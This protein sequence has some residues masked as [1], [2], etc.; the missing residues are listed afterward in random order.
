[1]GGEGGQQAVGGVQGGGVGRRVD[2]GDHGVEAA[3]G[4]VVGVPL[5]RPVRGVVVGGEDEAAAYRV[6]GVVDREDG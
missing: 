1:V 2:H 4:H 5:P 3:T 6:A